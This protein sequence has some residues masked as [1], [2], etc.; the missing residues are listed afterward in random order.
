MT[1]VEKI[2]RH[3]EKY[4]SITTLEAF[5]EYGITR[6]ASRIHDIKRAGFIVH[7][8]TETSTNRFG[9]PVWYARY[10]ITEG[11]RC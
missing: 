8:V 2:L 4:G 11:K 6:L 10:T 9:E 3:T 5:Q 1:Q 7:K